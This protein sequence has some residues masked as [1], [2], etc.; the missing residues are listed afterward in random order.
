MEEDP[1]PTNS[2][3]RVD[4]IGEVLQPSPSKDVFFAWKKGCVCVCV[5]EG[6]GEWEVAPA[7]E[8]SAPPSLFSE[9]TAGDLSLFL[10]AKMWDVGSNE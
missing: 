7:I 2:P 8:N 5:C 4:S 3:R 9:K 10:I 6:G 1:T